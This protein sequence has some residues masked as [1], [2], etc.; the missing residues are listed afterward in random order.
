MFRETHNIQIAVQEQDDY[1][2]NEFDTSA[3]IVGNGHSNIFNDTKQDQV[4][5][6]SKTGDEFPKP[7]IPLKYITMPFH[8][9]ISARLL[10][11]NST[12]HLWNTTPQ[13][14][15]ISRQ[16]SFWQSLAAHGVSANEAALFDSIVGH[17]LLELDGENLMQTD[18]EVLHF[19]ALEGC[20]ELYL[21][22][23]FLC[24]KRIYEAE[25][26]IAS[27]MKFFGDE[28]ARHL[29]TTIF[30][31]DL[32]DNIIHLFAN[33]LM[34][35]Y[36]LTVSNAKLDFKK[37][38]FGRAKKEADLADLFRSHIT[39]YAGR[40][41]GW[42]HQKSNNNHDEA[43]VYI[44]DLSNYWTDWRQA[45]RTAQFDFNL[46]AS[47]SEARLVRF[48]EL[49]KLLR[50]ISMKLSD[51]N[52]PN[53]LEIKYEHFAHLMPLPLFTDE[54]KIKKQINELVKPFKQNGYI[55]SFALKS[56][57]RGGSVRDARLR[58]RFDD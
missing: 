1:H 6:S 11:S 34:A 40:A 45:A 10:S 43:D 41:S 9:L 44:A 14:S 26:E 52:F 25:T 18:W 32:V 13:P 31:A 55:K 54:R 38:Q 28:I 12:T 17:T 20:A 58:M 33:N 21:A 4:L 5:K 57:W 53:W 27:E 46:L 24:K 37:S 30:T 29:P 42:H 15:S 49:T 35:S 3:M 19:D 16:Q 48:Y 51:D 7:Q 47:L 8:H 22:E 56:D 2:E 39:A 36:N 23:M 50:A